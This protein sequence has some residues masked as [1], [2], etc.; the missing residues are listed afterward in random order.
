MAPPIPWTTSATGR[1]GA[2]YTGDMAG[3]AVESFFRESNLRALRELAMREAAHEVEVRQHDRR[4]EVA[5]PAGDMAAEPPASA[6]PDVS[7][8]RILLLVT[9]DPSTAMLVRRARRV[10]DYL[11]GDCLALYVHREQHFSDLP[12]VEREEIDRLLNFARNLR[13]ETRILQGQD[14]AQT[15]VEFARRN[16]VTQIFLSRGLL[17]PRASRLRRN[18][19][20]DI[21]R[22]AHDMQIIVVATRR[23]E[24]DSKHRA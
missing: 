14:V 6:T 19:L 12:A 4:S 10:A 7:R 16:Q 18:L 21:I 17:R 24:N 15:L 9:E 11:H 13:V 22:L 1:R 5:A 2:V 20:R 8:E 3:K 23:N